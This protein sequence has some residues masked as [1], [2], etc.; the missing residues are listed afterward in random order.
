MSSNRFK[1]AKTNY[2]VRA[3][4]AA[5]YARNLLVKGKNTISAFE[6]FLSRK[7]RRNRLRILDCVAYSKK[8]HGI[9][10]IKNRSKAPK[11]LFIGC[12]DNTTAYLLQNKK[13]G[14][15]PLLY[16]LGNQ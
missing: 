9:K 3:V 6:N 1:I 10:K 4:D 7:P 13:I 15:F 2:W 16:T 12:S 11:C 5:C 8:R 14:K